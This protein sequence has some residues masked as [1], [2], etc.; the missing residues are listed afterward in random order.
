MHIK[1]IRTYQPIN[2]QESVDKKA[3]LEFAEVNSDSLL[4]TNLTA[5][6]TS[7]AIIT[8]KAK[9]KILFVYHLIYNSWSWVGGH[10][11]GNANFLEVAIQEALEETGLSEVRPIY[12]HPVALDN[13]LV[14]NHIKNGKY[15]GDH[16]H[17]NLTYLLEA[18]EDDE[19][20]I[21]DDENSGVKWFDLDK[22]LNNVSEERMIYIY[23]K[24]FKILKEGVNNNE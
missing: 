3:M 14:T 24:I 16:I 11:D 19:L 20:S 4:R 12:E 7:S 13:I 2:E 23:E 1:T 8:N 17:M 10:N 5:H 15:V 6:F 21:K 22:V 18:N 9:N